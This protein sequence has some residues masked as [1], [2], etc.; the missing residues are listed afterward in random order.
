MS[1]CQKLYEQA[2]RSTKNFRFADLC[3]LAECNGWRFLRQKASHVMYEH[4]DLAP[5]QGRFMN[6][7]ERNGMA[8]PEQ[9]KQLLAAIENLGDDQIQLLNSV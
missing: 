7:Q 1:N 8:K 5:D 2:Q 4:P 9:V 6:F 3:K